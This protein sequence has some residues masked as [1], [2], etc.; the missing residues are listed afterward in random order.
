MRP[1]WIDEAR[2]GRQ[3]KEGIE[4][5]VERVVAVRSRG[6]LGMQLLARALVATPRHQTRARWIADGCRHVSRNQ[7]D[8]AVGNESMFGVGSALL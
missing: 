1:A 3:A 6:G 7:P 4:A 5:V 2:A 8:P